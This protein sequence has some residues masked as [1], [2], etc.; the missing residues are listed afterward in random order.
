MDM[1]IVNP[2]QLTLY[3]DID[4]PLKDIIE[5]V[6]FN[7]DEDSTENLVNI[8]GEYSGKSKVDRFMK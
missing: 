1:G 3:D 5:D 7:R 4:K 2:G 6:I 8:A